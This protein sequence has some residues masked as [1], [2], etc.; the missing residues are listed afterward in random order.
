M[1]S[2]IMSGFYD[3][4]K[5]ADEVE[6]RMKAHSLCQKISEE[7]FTIN[8]NKIIH[9]VFE[10]YDIRVGFPTMTIALIMDKGGVTVINVVASSETSISMSDSC[11]A[12]NKYIKLVEDLLLK[13]NFMI[14]KE[15]F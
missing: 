5:L 12:E 9:M 8:K 7:E 15:N 2:L 11:E 3:A 1:P 6:E 10:R 4:R 13:K 14:D